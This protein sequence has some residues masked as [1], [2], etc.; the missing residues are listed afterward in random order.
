MRKWLSFVFVGI[1][2]SVAAS[3]LA[4]ERRELRFPD[5]PGFKTLKCDFHMHTV[6]SDGVV[7]PTVRVDEAWR[8][9]L[10]AIA[11]TDHIE[12]QPHK[13][14]LPTNFNRSYQIAAEAAKSRNL[15]VIHAAEITRDTPPGHFN[16]IFLQDIDPLKTDDLAEVFGLAAGQGAFIFWNHPYWKGPERGKWAEAQ[17]RAYQQKQL[18]GIEIC[19]GDEYCEQA[20]RWAVEKGL[21]IVGNSDIHQPSSDQPYTPEVHRTL[22]LVFAKERSVDA[23]RAAL[24]EGRTAVWCQ[25]VLYG[26][27]ALLAGVFAGA[28]EVRP[29]HLL[30]K[31]EVYFE[32][33]NRCEL[34]LQLGS[35]K[36]KDEH[37]RVL[38][39]GTTALLRLPR[40]RFNADGKVSFRVENL[41]TAPERVLEVQLAVPGAADK[42]E[43]Q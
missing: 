7:W 36:A 14:D 17:E 1:V 27:E 34:D 38:K 35:G 16:A 12:Y 15:L 10:D 39:A 5:L 31:N 23:I 9:G 33:V 43:P 32:V 22:T 4:Q 37:P 20:H 13:A 19:N 25:N 11:M 30:N 6:F 42:T 2:L 3:A 41:V 29:A 18:R 21:T 8:E 24:L 26:N 28:V 40:K